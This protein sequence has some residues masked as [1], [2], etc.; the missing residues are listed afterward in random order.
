MALALPVVTAF[1][2]PWRLLAV[3]VV[4]V[5]VWWFFAP[6]PATRPLTP[7]AIAR[8]EPEM[9]SWGLGLTRV[10]TTI[11]PLNVG[12]PTRSTAVEQIALIDQ[13]KG[14]GR[15]LVWVM[16]MPAA[17][18]VHRTCDSGA[19]NWT[20]R[21]GNDLSVGQHYQLGLFLLDDRIVAATLATPEER[22]AG[23]AV[24]V[25]MTNTAT[26]PAARY[27][28]NAQR[29]WVIGRVNGTKDTPRCAEAP[30]DL[31]GLVTFRRADPAVKHVGMDCQGNRVNAFD[32]YPLH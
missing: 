3:A 28:F 17:Y 30:S 32:Q 23:I 20:G 8:L 10:L 26:D 24:V 18:I 2:T 6:D 29:D 14:T 31:P 21:G 11:V 12:S 7:A 19:Q 5:A 4:A 25:H 15:R 13:Y 22:D 1:L 9:C 16:R 27:R